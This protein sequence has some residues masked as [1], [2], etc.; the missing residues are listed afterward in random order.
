MQGWSEF[1]TVTAGAAATLMGLLFVVVSMNGA[2]ILGAA[3]QHSRR[4]AEQA[5]QNYLAVLLVSLLAILP[6]M[7]VKLFGEITLSVTALAGVW[8]VVR[9]WL[10]LI[11]A[12]EAGTRLQSLR[13]QFSSLIGFGILIAAAARMAFGWGDNHY[14]FA[15]SMIV[16]LGAATT[17][18]WQLLLRMAEVKL[19]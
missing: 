3:H 19:N 18:S 13:R 16:L 4:L 11:R 10:A 2:A 7:D 6:A 15:S 1:Y 17:V 5:F 8:V 14:L 12:P 9:A